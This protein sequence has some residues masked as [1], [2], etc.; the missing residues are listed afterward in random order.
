MAEPISYSIS[1]NIEFHNGSEQVENLQFIVQKQIGQNEREPN[2]DVIFRYKFADEPDYIGPIEV[3]SDGIFVLSRSLFLDKNRQ[4]LTVSIGH[5]ENGLGVDFVEDDVEII[6]YI[7]KSGYAVILDNDVASLVY[8]S[9][10]TEK[11]DSAQSVTATAS[12]YENNKLVNYST[13]T[14]LYYE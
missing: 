12:L 1:K 11:L 7:S 10:G 3:N 9:D 8:N 6:N 14:Y 4:D 5:W 13:S 2:T